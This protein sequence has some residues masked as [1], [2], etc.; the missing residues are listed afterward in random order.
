MR[1]LQVADCNKLP[2]ATGPSTARS[3]HGEPVA[4]PT[5]IRRDEGLEFLWAV[6][7]DVNAVGDVRLEGRMRR[8]A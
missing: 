1:I 8:I 5:R 4:R 3:G 2:A 7:L 6:V